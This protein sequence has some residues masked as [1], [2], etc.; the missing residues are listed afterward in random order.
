MADEKL[1][2]DD[3]LIDDTEDAV[4][5]TVL[6]LCVVVVLLA[7]QIAVI[8]NIRPLRY[9]TGLIIGR[10]PGDRIRDQGTDDVRSAEETDL[11]FIDG[12]DIVRIA[13]LVDLEV[14]IAEHQGRILEAQ[15]SL[16]VL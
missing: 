3:E 16:Q 7:D 1:T 10:L 9:G 6:Q 13:F 14:E 15:A 2:N 5:E 4:E 11:V 8:D 12:S